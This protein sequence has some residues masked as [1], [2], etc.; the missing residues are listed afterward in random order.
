M[1][2][3][4]RAALRIGVPLAVLLSAL[5]LLGQLLVHGWGMESGAIPFYADLTDV[6]F[7]RSIPTFFQTA[8][9]LACAAT[10]WTVADDVRRCGGRDRRHWQVL[11]AAFLFLAADESL[12]LHERATEPVRETLGLGGVFHLAWIVVAV[13]L[14]ALFAASFLPFLRRLPRRTSAA[15]V[16]SG[17]LYLAGTVGMEMVGGVLFESGGPDTV[18]FSVATTAEELLEMLGMLLFLATVAD[19]R[20]R[21]LEARLRQIDVLEAMSVE[22]VARRAKSTSEVR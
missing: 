11:A 8:V 20:Q 16:A 17:A 18:A 6:D 9:L 21:H 1:T 7:E 22:P 3:R 10:L 5:S 14:V 2:V 4:A 19:F 15:I 13:P 12:A